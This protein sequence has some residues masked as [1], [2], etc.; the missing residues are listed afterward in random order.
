MLWSQV[1]TYITK[2]VLKRL[3]PTIITLMYIFLTGDVNTETQHFNCE[4]SCNSQGIRISDTTLLVNRTKDRTS[5]CLARCDHR[6]PTA[7]RGELATPLEGI[8]LTDKIKRCAWRRSH[9][10]GSRWHQAN[11]HSSGVWLSREPVSDLKPPQCPKRRIT[12]LSK[13]TLHLKRDGWHCYPVF[14]QSILYEHLSENE[15]VKAMQKSA[16]ETRCRIQ[17][18]SFSFKN[19]SIYWRGKYSESPTYFSR[20]YVNFES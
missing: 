17:G 1:Q 15:I 7:C 8:L 16:R 11:P 5:T 6:W 4:V 2:W 12:A 10:E 14:M 20:Q 13:A 3:L 9:A 18:R 19:R